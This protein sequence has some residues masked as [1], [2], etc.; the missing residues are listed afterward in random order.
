MTFRCRRALRWKQDFWCVNY[1]L[2]RKNLNLLSQRYLP[3]A[4]SN[5]WIRNSWRTSIQKMST[6]TKVPR[7]IATLRTAKSPQWSIAHNPNK[8]FFQHQL[9]KT[10]SQAKFSTFSLKY[11]SR[12]TLKRRVNS[13]TASAKTIILLV[14][15]VLH[16]D[17]KHKNRYK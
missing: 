12:I 13:S 2:Q 14:S 8:D 9:H 7:D 15:I 16:Q 11:F 17:S 1:N 4:P 5:Q 3:A 6:V 10:L